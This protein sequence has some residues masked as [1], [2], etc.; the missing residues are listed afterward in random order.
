MRCVMYMLV[1][2]EV[3]LAVVVVLVDG[4]GICGSVGGVGKW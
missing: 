1:V 2:V 4:I 3:V